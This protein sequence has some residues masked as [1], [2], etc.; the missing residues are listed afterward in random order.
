MPDLVKAAAFNG[1]I[2]GI[3]VRQVLDTEETVMNQVR[4]Y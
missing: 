2:F 3:Y 4:M 1:Y